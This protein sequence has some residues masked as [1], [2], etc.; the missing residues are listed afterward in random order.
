MLKSPPAYRRLQLLVFFCGLAALTA[1]AAEP[2]RTIDF[3]LKDLDGKTHTLSEYRGKWVVINFW[4]TTC[5]PC[6]KEMPELSDFHDR[7]KDHDA[8]V[9][10]MDFE[11]IRPSWIRRFLDSVHVTYPIL[12]WGASPATP[13]G[14]VIALPTTYIISPEGKM[15]AQ[16]VGPMTAA[17]IE[18]YIRRKTGAVQTDKPDME[19]EAG[20]E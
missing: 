2:E 14:L 19:H 18:A 7:H 20:N 5:P 12:P 4:A 6:I 3:S 13:F 16:Q 15:V 17:D 1:S 8:V 9:L 11:D 10:G